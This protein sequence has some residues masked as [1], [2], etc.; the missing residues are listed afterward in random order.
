MTSLAYWE[1]V[2]GQ[3]IYSTPVPPAN[4]LEGLSGDRGGQHS[5]RVSRQYCICFSWTKEGP[6][7]VEVVDYP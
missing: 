3:D 6:A 1:I 2:K 5:I 4:H 7:N